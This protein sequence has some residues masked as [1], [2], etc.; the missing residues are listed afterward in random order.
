MI[1]LRLFFFI[2]LFFFALAVAMG[3]LLWV[4]IRLHLQNPFLRSGNNAAPPSKGGNIIE[5][6]YKRLD[7]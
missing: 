1:I 4:K 5:G 2:F 7:E 6:E 3:A